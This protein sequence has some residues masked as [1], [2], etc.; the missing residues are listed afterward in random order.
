MSKRKYEQDPERNTKRQRGHNKTEFTYEF[1]RNAWRRAQDKFIVTNPSAG[2]FVVSAPIP[3]TSERD[4]ERYRELVA[5]NGNNVNN[6]VLANLNPRNLLEAATLEQ[7]QKTNPALAQRV[8]A[9]VQRPQ[10]YAPPAARSTAAAAA[11]AGAGVGIVPAA[12][13]AG[14]DMRNRP[15]AAAAAAAEYIDPRVAELVEKDDNEAIRAAELGGETVSTAKF[16]IPDIQF[17]EYNPSA[18]KQTLKLNKQISKNLGYAPPSFLFTVYNDLLPYRNLLVQYCNAHQCSKF[19][20]ATY[21]M[22][23]PTSGTLELRLEQT[24]RIEEYENPHNAQQMEEI[25][26]AISA[27]NQKNGSLYNGSLYQVANERNLGILV[28][29][30]VTFGQRHEMLF[31]IVGLRNLIGQYSSSLQ[32]ADQCANLSPFTN[33][34][35]QY[36]KEQY[37][38][39]YHHCLKNFLWNVIGLFNSKYGARYIRFYVNQM[40]E[41]TTKSGLSISSDVIS[42]T[43]IHESFIP[44]RFAPIVRIF[45]Y[46]RTCY[47]K[48][49]EILYVSY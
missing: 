13:G 15:A 38:Q 21:T 19:N 26:K 41:N 48:T 35:L 45:R 28:E 22:Q 5:N 12:A 47:N 27:D 3:G 6:D 17:T 11:A 9:S 37:V 18:W 44:L 34:P 1:D 49:H 16:D 24:P 2:T 23:H 29:R 33:Q 32:F 42:S 14:V 8:F 36:M 7:L 10:I 31:E 40:V 25:A 4:F 20:I 30:D 46:P 43:K 39:Y